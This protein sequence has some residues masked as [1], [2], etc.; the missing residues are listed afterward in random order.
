[1]IGSSVGIRLVEIGKQADVEV[2][3]NRL[4]VPADVR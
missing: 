2:A 1:M 4:Q 3:A